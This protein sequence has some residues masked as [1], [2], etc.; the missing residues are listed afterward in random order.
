[1][2]AMREIHE[3]IARTE[4]GGTPESEEIPASGAD[5]L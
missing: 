2:E 4:E 1:M 5:S 3:E